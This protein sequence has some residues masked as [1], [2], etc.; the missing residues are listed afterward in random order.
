MRAQR[1]PYLDKEKGRDGTVKHWYFRYKNMRWPLPGDPHN[2]KEANDA[3]WRLRTTVA[4]NAKAPPQKAGHA[5]GSWGALTDDFFKSA[6][7]QNLEATSQALYRRIL[8]PLCERHGQKRVSTLM[9]AHIRGWRDAR[10]ETPGMANMLVKVVKRILSFAVDNEY[11]KDNPAQRLKLFKLGEHRAWTDDECATFEKR[12]PPGT[13][14]RRTYM[15]AKYTAQ[16][17]GDLAALTQANRKDGGIQLVQQKTGTEVFVPEFSELTAELARGTQNMSL[18]VRRS[19][20]SH[21]S[22][23]LSRWFAS[24]IEAAGLPDDCVLHGL[25][26]TASVLLVESGSGAPQAMAVTGHR[27]PAVFDQYIRDANQ[28]KLAAGAI[29]GLER[30]ARRTKT[31]KRTLANTAKQ[32]GEA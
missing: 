15:L 26:K 27:D 14:E 22:E 31:A 10:G 21:D 6:E 5:A 1:L 19:G 4:G 17:C 28:K 18:L 23:S 9:R 16:R 2:S 12:W 24:A 32:A 8:E 20:A 13:M 3:Y 30:N 29:R 7:L 11:R 25:R